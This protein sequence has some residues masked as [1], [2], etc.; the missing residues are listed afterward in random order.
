[1]AYSA[2]KTISGPWL[3]QKPII[4]ISGIGHTGGHS[5]AN[6]VVPGCFLRGAAV[7]QCSVSKTKKIRVCVS[8]Q[9]TAMLGTFSKRGIVVCGSLTLLLLMKPGDEELTNETQVQ[10]TS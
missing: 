10:A 4:M 9:T 8:A 1:M 3:F 7:T 5:R 2:Q 6:T